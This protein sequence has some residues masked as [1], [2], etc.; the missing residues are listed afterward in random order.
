MTSLDDV[1]EGQSPAVV[2]MVNDISIVSATLVFDGR[3]LTTS[4]APTAFASTALVLA[5]YYVFHLAYPRPYANFLKALDVVLHD[6][7]DEEELHC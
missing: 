3:R 4:I 5:A 1:H 2:I 7:F 6:D